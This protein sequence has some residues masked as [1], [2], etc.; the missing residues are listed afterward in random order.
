M[1]KKWERG[2]SNS[3]M[4]SWRSCPYKWYL[5]YIKKCKPIYWDATV[6][7]VGSKFHEAA[8]RY[9]KFRYIINPTVQEAF[10]EIYGII[11]ED[12]DTTLA[13]TVP[14]FQKIHKC[15]VNWAN[16]EVKRIA[17]GGT[18]PESELK[19]GYDGFYGIIDIADVANQK[20]G[21]FKSQAYPSVDYYQGVLYAHLLNHKF[22]WDLE[23]FPFIFVQHEDCVKCADIKS[24]KAETIMEYQRISRD[25]VKEAYK[26]AKK[27][28]S[29][30]YRQIFTHE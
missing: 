10:D 19:L 17:E 1:Y 2:I 15:A 22:G 27:L 25:E 16:W 13:K 9:Y 18:K 23:E 29:G 6:F 8:E 3:Q 30:G 14:M 4:G 24:K 20:P 28:V 26:K 5:N 12:W 21:D 11:K 7:E